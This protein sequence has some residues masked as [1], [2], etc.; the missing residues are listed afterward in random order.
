MQTVT[1]RQTDRQT[2]QRRHCNASRGQYDALIG[3]LACWS[4]TEREP[5]WVTEFVSKCQ[6]AARQTDWRQ[7]QLD[8]RERKVQSASNSVSPFSSPAATRSDAVCRHPSVFHLSTADV[9]SYSSCCSSRPVSG[10][11]HSA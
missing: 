10:A 2:F 5:L 6:H 7:K 8:V 9:S 1:D 3:W 11:G 4:M